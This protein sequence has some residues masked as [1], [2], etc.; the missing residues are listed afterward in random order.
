MLIIFLLSGFVLLFQ[1]VIAEVCGEK[2]QSL[3]VFGLVGNYQKTAG[4]SEQ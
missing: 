3:K 2:L 4:V 1:L